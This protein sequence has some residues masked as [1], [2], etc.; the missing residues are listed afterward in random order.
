M[1]GPWYDVLPIV[2]ISECAARVRGVSHAQLVRDNAA[3]VAHRDLHGPYRML[4][5]LAHV[6]TVALRLASL[7]MRYFDFGGADA[8]VVR[9]CVVESHR[10]GIPAPLAP[11]FIY[12]TEGFVRIALKLAGATFAGVRYGPPRPEGMLSGIP[13]VRLRFEIS[14]R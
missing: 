13:L 1:S 3:W 12:A 10:Y 9:D 8:A 2:A 14:W 5:S 7:S 11:W 6:E 4:L